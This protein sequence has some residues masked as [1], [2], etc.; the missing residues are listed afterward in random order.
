MPLIFTSYRRLDSIDVTARLCDRLKSRFGERNVFLDYQRML[1]GEDFLGAIDSE[2]DSS[3]AV[4]SVI[5][6]KWTGERGPDQ[7][8]RIHDPAD[9][10][11]REL[12]RAQRRGV[13]ILPVL[14]G[15]AGYLQ[16]SELPDSLKK[17]AS[18]HAL[19]LRSG[20]DFEGDVRRIIE[21][22]ERLT[23]GRFFSARF[24][25]GS[26]IFSF[27]PPL[28][29]VTSRKRSATLVTIRSGAVLGTSYLVLGTVQWL[30][31]MKEAPSLVNPLLLGVPTLV[32][33]SIGSSL[34]AI[35]WL[36]IRLVALF[37]RRRQ[38]AAL[39]E[40]AV[41][42]LA[43]LDTPRLLSATSA[44]GL[45]LSLEQKHRCP[46]ITDKLIAE[47]IRSTA[48]TLE[49][50]RSGEQL[51]HGLERLNELMLS[52]DETASR[53]CSIAVVDRLGAY[54]QSQPILVGALLLA[55]VV[56]V[57]RPILFGLAHPGWTSAIVAGVTAIALLLW[58]STER[59]IRYWRPQKDGAERDLAPAVLAPDKPRLLTDFFLMA[60]SSRSTWAAVLW[61]QVWGPLWENVMFLW[62]SDRQVA[63]M[64]DFRF[65]VAQGLWRELMT[66]D[67]QLESD[68][69]RDPVEGT[70]LEQRFR[71]LARKLWI[72]TGEPR[73]RTIEAR[74]SI[75]RE[76]RDS[77]IVGLL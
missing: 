69:N 57:T 13:P 40:L 9:V 7:I 47:A 50:A 55:L 4:V 54:I 71:E 15:G 20:L 2:I 27:S 19:E 24:F 25:G 62:R 16:P 12:E 23:M 58:L 38:E 14:I 32:L 22:L 42:I 64:H 74:G 77:G 33:A 18:L 52:I 37:A 39:G 29:S 72:V 41:L 59:A 67:I 34:L 1:G 48:V 70:I 31:S 51:E 46:M 68:R 36:R 63:A 17:L 10:V 56:A 75:V 26:S 66:V 44:R 30:V 73:F 53:L 3:N 5:G 76:D 11:R 45:A 28:T 60:S 6:P 8:S 21:C 49:Y 65:D 35:S 43:R 61:N